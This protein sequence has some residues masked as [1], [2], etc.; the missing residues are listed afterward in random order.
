MPQPVAQLKHP[1]SAVLAPDLV[2]RIQVG[3]VGKFLAQPQRRVF[4]M[5]SNGGLERAELSGEIEM[6]IL[7]KMLI[8]EDQDSVF[9]EG[10]VDRGKISRLDFFRQ[11]DIAHF[12]CERGRDRDDGDGHG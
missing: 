4:A 6:L 5:E 9:D 1:N 11:F 8:R 2:R 7:G 3:H 12:R 10:F